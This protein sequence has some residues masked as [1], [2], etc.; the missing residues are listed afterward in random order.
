MDTC[1]WSLDA[2]FKECYCADVAW[3][4]IS[5]HS[6]GSFIAAQQFVQKLPDREKPEPM[7]YLELFSPEERY[8]RGHGMKVWDL[9]L[10]CS[11]Y[12]HKER[13]ERSTFR[14]LHS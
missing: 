2:T 13:P 6:L 9:Y 11:S 5:H 1:R 8:Q 7:G 14:C 3:E 10:F 4:H 12:R